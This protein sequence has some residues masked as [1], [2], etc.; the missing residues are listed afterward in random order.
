MVAIGW[1]TLVTLSLGI[2]LLAFLWALR[3][4][5][6]SD[7]ARARYL[8]LAE[9][10]PLSS[11]KNP[12]KITVEVYVL[13]VIAGIALTGTFASIVLSVLRLRG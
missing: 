7:Q 13:L 8:P 4:G 9:D 5:Q 1:I 10:H 12:G 3:N 2:S 11:P 6:F